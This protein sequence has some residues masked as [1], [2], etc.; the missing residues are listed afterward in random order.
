MHPAD[1]GLGDVAGASPLRL[2]GRPATRARILLVEDDQVALRVLENLFLADGFAISTAMNGEEALIEA[3]RVLPDI[4]LTDL[5]MEP[6]G[7]V[8][9]LTCLHELDANLGAS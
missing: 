5:L 1:S 3:R 2:T 4:V 8:E 9:L 6:M 7:G